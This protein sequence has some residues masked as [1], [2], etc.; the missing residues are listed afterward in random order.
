MK[1]H[2]VPA[3]LLISSFVCIAHADKQTL[4][5]A[6]IGGLDMSGVWPELEQAA[7][8]ALGFEIDTVA[9]APKEKVV[10]AFTSGA[11]DVLLMHGGDETFALEGQNYADRQQ[12]WG[13][14][15]FVIVGPDNDPAGVG[16]A[17]SGTEAMTRIQSSAAPLVLF[18]DVGSLQVLRRLLDSAG[19]VPRDQNLLPDSV[20]RPQDILIQAAESQAY[21]IVGHMPVAFDR[22]R[23][24]GVRVLLSGDPAM[25]RAYVVVTPGANHP[26][27]AQA[28]QQATQFA[29]WLVSSTGQTALSE[30]G[31]IN[32]DIWV[33]G[34]A[35]G[36]ALIEFDPTGQSRS[37]RR[38]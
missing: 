10:P 35:A 27:S 8:A 29:D 17:T 36:A 38:N 13:Y 19:L 37:D 21:I 20:R 18:R 26:A 32:G 16:G 9:A 22:M 30:A 4:H 15:E 31:N 24:D 11:A 12:V 6:V 1:L 7:E 3:L 34:R 33:F 14:N 25:R 2:F 23:A 5:V 28:R